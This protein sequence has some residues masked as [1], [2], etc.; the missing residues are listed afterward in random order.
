MQP[1]DWEPSPGRFLVVLPLQAGAS[2]GTGGCSSAERNSFRQP[3]TAQ[4]VQQ[5]F[6]CLAAVFQ[7]ERRV[8]FRTA[9]VSSALGRLM[10]VRV[11][12]STSGADVG[13]GLRNAGRQLLGQLGQTGGQREAH[14]QPAAL[15]LH[16][17]RG[18]RFQVL[19]L[20]GGMQQVVLQVERVL[21]GGGSWLNSTPDARHC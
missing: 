9:P 6:A 20:G 21:D 4:Q 5:R 10:A 19:R 16:P 13:L 18:G 2:C 17:R 8:A 7:Q 12:G 1:S 11:S 3:L 15:V 14:W